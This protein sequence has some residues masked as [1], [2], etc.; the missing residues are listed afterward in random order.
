MKSRQCNART[1]KARIDVARHAVPSRDRPND[2]ISQPIAIVFEIEFR[3]FESSCD[4]YQAI[5]R[6]LEV[7]AKFLDY[8]CFNYL[9][10]SYSLA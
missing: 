7:F 2:R 1:K 3:I 10:Y 5:C 6:D 8:F 9:N 4:R